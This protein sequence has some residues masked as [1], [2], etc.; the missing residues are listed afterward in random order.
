[1]FSWYSAPH[2]SRVDMEGSATKMSRSCSSAPPGSAIS[3]STLPL[4]PAPWSWIVTIGLSAPI[5]M[6]D[7]TTRF[8]LVVRDRCV[9]VCGC[10]F[11]VCISR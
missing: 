6:H 1:M 9:R 11:S 3:F 8:I 7:R 4:P 2:I 10:A 5:S